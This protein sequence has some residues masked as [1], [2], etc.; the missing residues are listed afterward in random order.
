MP[1]AYKI[2]LTYEPSRTG[3]HKDIV[4]TL[5]ELSLSNT[6]YMSLGGRNILAKIDNEKYAFGYNQAVWIDK[7][8][9]YPIPTDIGYLWQDSQVSKDSK[10]YFGL[11]SL[12]ESFE[13][14][15]KKDFA[16]LYNE[17]F[18]YSISWQIHNAKES[19]KQ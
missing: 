9:I 3:S 6:T 8:G 14:G 11:L 13:L 10:K 16:T 1:Q 18:N 2:N 5:Y 19:E 15:D 17:L 4:P 12:D 7:K